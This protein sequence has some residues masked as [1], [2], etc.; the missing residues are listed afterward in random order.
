M[1]LH[2]GDNISI[3]K[4]DI[5]TILDKKTVDKSKKTREFINLMIESGLL[6]NNNNKNNDI[7]TYLVTKDNNKGYKLYT[8]NISS[9]TLFNR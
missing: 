5:V 3:Y 9:M 7:K 1:F 8:S 4:D 6:F 2:I